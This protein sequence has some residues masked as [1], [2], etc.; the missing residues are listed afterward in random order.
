MRGVLLVEYVE[1]TAS[2]FGRELFV[3]IRAT[4]EFGPVI[5]AGLGGVDTEYLAS[6][7]RPGL[8]VAKA[9]AA[10]LKAEDFLETFKG[11]VAYEILAGKARGHRRIVSDGELLRCFRAF[12]L[13]AQRFCV[14]RGEEGPDVAELEVNPFAFRGNALVPLDGR[15]RLATAAKARPRRPVDKLA[16][17][18]EPQTIAVLGA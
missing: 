12:I 18:L 14:D 1:Q 11:T 8:A 17:L 6:K 10:D 2:G 3:G 9:P 5:A 4:R 13:L 15:G 16:K 7:M